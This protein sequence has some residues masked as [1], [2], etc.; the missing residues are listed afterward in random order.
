MEH[1]RALS[2]SRVPGGNSLLLIG[3][4]STIFRL[5]EYWLTD[6]SIE[7]IFWWPL[8]AGSLSNSALLA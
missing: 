3:G 6:I 5:C 2:Q 1:M 8:K 4:C 7:S